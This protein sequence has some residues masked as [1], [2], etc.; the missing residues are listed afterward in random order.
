LATTVEIGKRM[1]KTIIVVEDG[2]GFFTSR[3]LGPFVNEALYLL[4][5]GASIEQIDKAVS[6]WGWPVGPIAL[7]D[8]VGLDVAQKAGKV[9][10][11][12]AGDRAQPSPIFELMINSGRKGRK[13]GRGF[14]DY[15]KKPK[16]VDE[17]VYQL[18]DWQPRE[19][20]D[21]EIIER[22]WMQMLNETARC[23][24]DGIISNPNDIDIGVIFGFGFPPF[25]G[26]MLREADRLGVDYVVSR[27]ET[28]ADRHGD[29][30]APAQLLVDM[31]KKGE[32]FHE[33]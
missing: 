7:L 19:I 6:G 8:E 11:E 3:V 4:Q 15:S 12:H 27:L 10:L 32:K 28:Y 20:D 29:R 14:Y 26:G 16:R 31:A 33:G 17:S 18:F 9:M 23:I 13:G 2:P 30:L 24:E 25:R 21:Q 1:G 22:T 5:E